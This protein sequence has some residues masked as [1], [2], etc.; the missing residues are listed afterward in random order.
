MP[1]SFKALPCLLH[2]C[3]FNNLAPL[4]FQVQSHWSSVNNLQG[5]MCPF[6]PAFSPSCFQFVHKLLCASPRTFWLFICKIIISE[7]ASSILQLLQVTHLG[8]LS[9]AGSY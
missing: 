2:L 4:P 8:H 3:S 1:A 6:D 7:Q 9:H 5:L